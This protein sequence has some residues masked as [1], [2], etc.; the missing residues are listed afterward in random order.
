MEIQIKQFIDIVRSGPKFEHEKVREILK[1]DSS[2]EI[3]D[4]FSL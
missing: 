3:N 1:T 2:A 4:R